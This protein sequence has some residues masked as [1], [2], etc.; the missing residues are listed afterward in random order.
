MKERILAGLL[1]LYGNGLKGKPQSCSEVRDKILT[2]ICEEIEKVENPYDETGGAFEMKGYSVFEDCRQ[3]I[4]A[5]LRP[6]ENPVGSV[7]L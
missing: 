4:L 1:V 6:V 2:L 5:L 7:D 3:K